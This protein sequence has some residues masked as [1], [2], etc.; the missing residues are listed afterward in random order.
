MLTYALLFSKHISLRER[1]MNALNLQRIY[2][3]VH[4][5]TRIYNQA[6]AGFF[7]LPGIK[8]CCTLTSLIGL[9]NL[10]L[11]AGKINPI[12]SAGFLNIVISTTLLVAAVLLFAG[13]IHQQSKLFKSKYKSRLLREYKIMASCKQLMINIGNMYPVKKITML[14]YFNL[15]MDNLVNILI[16]LHNLKKV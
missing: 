5:L 6:F 8:M 10:I 9:S 13:N 14:N 12:I 15:Y 7:G 16:G 2:N 4:L 1:N 11:T 3:S